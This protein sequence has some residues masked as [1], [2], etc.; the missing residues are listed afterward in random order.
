MPK[1]KTRNWVS[2][3][4]R[5]HHEPSDGRKIAMSVLPSPSKSAGT[6]LSP[7]APNWMIDVPEPPEFR[8]YQVAL[9]GRK[10]AASVLPSPS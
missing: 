8:I 9:E 4:R 1:L 7:S 5:Y 10:T 6:G 2:V 3:E